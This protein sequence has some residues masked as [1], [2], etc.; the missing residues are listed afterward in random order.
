MSRPAPDPLE[1]AP[2]ANDE[3]VR[4]WLA[5]DPAA[6]GACFRRALALRPGWD[7]ARHHLAQVH[8]ARGEFDV[9]WLLHEARRTIPPLPDP[10][11]PLPYPEWRG[12][13]LTGKRIVVFGEQ[14]LGDQIMFARFLPLLAARGARVAFVCAPE[15]VP[16]YPGSTS[17]WDT[18]APAADL[19]AHLGSLPLHLQRGA[20]PPP[21]APQI[22][23]SQGGGIGVVPS[24][25]TE[26]WNDAHR[27]LFG[28]DAERLLALGRDL[29]P[30][31]T[32]ARDFA[33]TARIVAGLDL[34]IS[35]DTSSAHLAASLGKP[36][37]ILLP[38]HGVDWRW[39]FE[40]ETSAWYRSARLLRQPQPGRWDAVLDRLE[41][42]LAHA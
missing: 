37:W 24:G 22:A 25:R 4:H 6:A 15:L 31:A 14:G 5:R 35:V 36:T 27:S 12:E 16:L 10:Q 23:L 17:G 41:A 18:R 7:V 42:E 21:Y 39:G 32:G 20:L 33:K 11:V 40:G 8:L 1:A 26:F 2:T 28:R 34:V 30:E 29:R 38:A 19:W 9:G 3:G 13:S